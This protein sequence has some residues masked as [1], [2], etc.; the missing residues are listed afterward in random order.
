M[1]CLR[2]VRLGEENPAVN[3]VLHFVDEGLIVVIRV[4]VIWIG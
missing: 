3:L 2:K 1:S 4:K